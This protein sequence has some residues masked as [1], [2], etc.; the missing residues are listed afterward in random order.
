VEVK[1]RPFGLGEGEAVLQGSAFWDGGDGGVPAALE[2]ADE[3]SFDFGVRH[4]S[5]S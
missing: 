1:F 2:S 4:G 3:A 5:R